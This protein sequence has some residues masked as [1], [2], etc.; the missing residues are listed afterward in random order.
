MYHD[1]VNLKSSE[2]EATSQTFLESITVSDKDVTFVESKTRKQQ[3]SE[4]W[5]EARKNRIMA[6]Q[7]GDVIKRRDF[8]KPEGLI[9]SVLG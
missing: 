9:K 1:S 2:C 5:F 3:K 7:F 4:C 8:N 6:S